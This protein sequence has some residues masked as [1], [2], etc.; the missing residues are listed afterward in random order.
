MSRSGYS[1]DYG[2]DNHWEMI[3]WR[4]AV[5]SAIRGK[6]GQAFLKEMLAALD[7]IESRRLIAHELVHEGDACAMGAVGLAR[8]VDMSRLDPENIEGVAGTF[9]ISDALAKEIAFENDQ[10]FSYG[11]EETPE[12]RYARMRKWVESHIKLS[13]ADKI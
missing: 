13:A 5:A 1:E 12:A 4:G 7:G 8:G 11:T 3:M 9:G 10:D 6:R 2:C